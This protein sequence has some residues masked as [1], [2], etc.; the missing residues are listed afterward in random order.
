MSA[1]ITWY[2]L[3]LRR[4]KI[5]EHAGLID[6]NGQRLAKFTRKN[7]KGFTWVTFEEGLQY[8]LIEDEDFCFKMRM[9]C[10]SLRTNE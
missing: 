8:P 3:L 2:S 6:L 10:K 7:L 1:Y 9:T 4:V 5:S